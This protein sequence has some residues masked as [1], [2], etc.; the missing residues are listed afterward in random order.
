MQPQHPQP[1]K[2]QVPTK[3]RPVPVRFSDWA[4]I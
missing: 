1:A 2:G 3:E 4:S